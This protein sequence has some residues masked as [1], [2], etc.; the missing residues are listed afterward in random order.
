M[1]TWKLY[2]AGGAPMPLDFDSLKMIRM[3]T[4]DA[5]ETRIGLYGEFGDR[6]PVNSA[7]GTNWGV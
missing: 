1:S 4:D 5:Y 3:A 7:R 2:S 6:L